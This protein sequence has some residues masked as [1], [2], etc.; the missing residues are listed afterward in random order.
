MKIPQPVLDRLACPVC[1][2]L[3]KENRMGLTCTDCQRTFPIFNDSTERPIINFL[4]SDNE[5]Q[6]ELQ[7]WSQHWDIE[8]Q[9]SFSQKF[10]SI[11]RK[12][13]FSRTV[14]YFFNRYFPKTGVFA[15]AGSGTSETSIYINKN[16]GERVLVAV[17]IVLPVLEKNHIVMDTRIGGDIFKMP[18]HNES[19]DGVW[20][21]G[22]MEHFSHPQIDQILQEFYRVLKP[23]APIL[24]LWPASYSIPQRILRLLEKIIN[25]RS[26]DE[27]NFR[28]H[29]PEIS[30][31][32]S[33]SQGQNVLIRNHYEIAAVDSGMR[34]LMAFITITGIKR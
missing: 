20:N 10:F 7:D 25:T 12:T 19:L 1:H 30:Q 9:N 29:P 21:V 3:L 14:A 11:Y 32:I 28:F 33:T 23:G 6:T 34:S 13:V 26:K 2:S 15:E 5:V 17:D 22:V 18:F 4:I 31:L 16:H 24:L 8:M 27:P